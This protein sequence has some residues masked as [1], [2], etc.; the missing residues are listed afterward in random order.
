MTPADRAIVARLKR[1]REHP[2]QMVREEFKVEP[3]AWQAEALEAF[4]H[5]PRLAM[6]ACKGPGK[7]AV[8]AWLGLNFL[9]TRSHPRIG[10]TSITEGNLNANL[11]PEL[12]KWMGVSPFFTEQFT[13][14]KTAIVHKQHWKTWW[15]QARGWPKQADPEQQSTALAGL[16][17]DF[18]MWILD[19]SGGMPQAIMTTAEAIFLSGIEQHVV[20]AGNPTHTTGPLHRACTTDRAHWYVVTITGDPRRADRSPR[21]NLAECQKLI[22]TYGRDNPWVMVNVL[23][24]FPPSSINSLL[25]VEDV[26]AAMRRHIPVDQYRHMQKRLGI[27][28]ARFGDDRTVIFP[29]QGLAAFRPRV[30]RNARGTAIA[31]KA[32]V[33]AHNWSK[34]GTL[35]LIFVDD[36]GGW[37]HSCI[38]ALILA[39][40]PVHPIVYSE[41]ALDPRY[42]NRRAEFWIEGAKAVK[43]GAALPYIPE[44][45]PELTEP[46]YTFIGGVFVL[47]EKDLVKVRLGR[48]PDLA[49]AYFQTYA[50]PDIPEDF[51]AGRGPQQTL[52]DGD[53][54]EAPRGSSSNVSR[55]LHDEDPY[56]PV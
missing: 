11:W 27:D 32:Q 20:Q 5:N 31:A 25:G 16:H 8:L 34:G 29:R 24:E 4:P 51:L 18:V 47:E 38:D 28:V 30:M 26:E 54:Y 40:M 49:D 15:M 1:W 19:E 10:A 7:T 45:I 37:G 12:A 46:T 50:L 42:K 35:P 56:N 2:L 21:M 9:G 41:R 17:A 55:T 48:S 43:A 22:D 23:G 33:L 52:H 6:K 3:D 13:W 44:M 14:T 39:G 53:P 36:T